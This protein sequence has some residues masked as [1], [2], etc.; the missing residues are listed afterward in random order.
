MSR[1]RWE[2]DAYL[3][4]LLT[5]RQATPERFAAPKIATVLN[6]TV[7]GKFLGRDICV[8]AALRPFWPT[9]PVTAG[10]GQNIGAVGS[11]RQVQR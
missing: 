10:I 6:L 5:T 9:V 11:L 2:L 8:P 4:A 7:V 1:Y 3:P